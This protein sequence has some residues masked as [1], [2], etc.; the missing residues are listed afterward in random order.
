MIKEKVN[1]LIGNEDSDCATAK[2]VKVD[3]NSDMPFQ[4]STNF[5]Q[6][7]HDY[8]ESEVESERR[9]SQLE[10]RKNVLAESDSCEEFQNIDII[11]TIISKPENPGRTMES[12]LSKISRTLS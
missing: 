5:R 11:D 4:K 2:T 1:G 7:I 6:I 10:S 3:K 9:R 12:G 8:N